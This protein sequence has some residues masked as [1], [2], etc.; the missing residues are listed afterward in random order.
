M[1]SYVKGTL[2][3]GEEIKETVKLHWF[4]YL[5]S[6]FL[7]LI[8]LFVV[9]VYFI[10]PA[11]ELVILFLF[12]LFG[13]LYD[14]LTLCTMEMVVTNKRVVYRKG[15]IS[16]KTEELR[17]DKIESIEVMQ[18]ILGRIFRFGNICFS[19]LGI[20]KVEFKGIDNPWAVKS[21]VETIIG[22]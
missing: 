18:S 15:I 22:N 20:S 1:M 2:S 16:I 12:L 8:M 21:K 11:K 9:V 10:V 6:F 7:G 3:Q 5:R 19:G 13:F 14:I 4:N 17:T